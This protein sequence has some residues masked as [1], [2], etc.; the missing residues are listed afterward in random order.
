MRNCPKLEK[1]STIKAVDSG[2]MFRTTRLSEVLIIAFARD[3]RAK[4]LIPSLKTV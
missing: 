2:S 4:L 3:F 1:K